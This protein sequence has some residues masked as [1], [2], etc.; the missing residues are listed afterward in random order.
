[1]SKIKAK[2]VFDKIFHGETNFITPDVLSYYTLKN[3][4]YVEL[5]QGEGITHEK[6]YGVTVIETNGKD[7]IKRHDL[8]KPFHNKKDAIEY[9]KSLGEEL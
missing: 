6:I 8:S 9:I 1:M 3:G 4:L 7:Y 2:R 5:S